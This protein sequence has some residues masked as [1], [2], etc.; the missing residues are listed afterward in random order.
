MAASVQPTTVYRHLCWFTNAPFYLELAR[1]ERTR[2]PEQIGIDAAHPGKGV[3][4][5]R[6]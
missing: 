3:E 6:E 5:D 2:G 4:D 1:S